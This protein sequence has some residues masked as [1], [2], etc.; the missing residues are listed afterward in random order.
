MAEIDISSSKLLGFK[1]CANFLRVSVSVS[2]DF[3]S[4]KSFDLGKFGLEKKVSVLVPKKLLSEKSLGFGELGL[5]KKFRFQKIWSRKKSQFS[6]LVSI[7]R[8]LPILEGF[9][10]GFGEFGLGKKV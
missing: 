6:L 7:L 9:G 5:G 10:I 3:V 2:E 8:F 1:T 4:E